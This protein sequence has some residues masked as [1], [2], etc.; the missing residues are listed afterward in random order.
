MRYVLVV[1]VI[2]L[3]AT[4]LLVP[5]SSQ[6]V[7]AAQSAGLTLQALSDE[8]LDQIEASSGHRVGVL[9]QQV[10]P[11][12]AAAQ[13][14]IKAGDVLLT[15]G[16]TGVASPQAVDVA[17]AQA[18]GAVQIMAMRQGA[19]GDFQP[20]TVTMGQGSGTG[21]PAQAAMVPTGGASPVDALGLV[22][23]PLPTE[24]LDAI[25]KASGHRVGIMVR[26]VRAGSPAAQGGIQSGDILLGI[27]NT[28]LASV[29][30]A[31]AALQGQAGTVPILG[32][33]RGEDGK[34]TMLAFDVVVPAPQAGPA[35][36]GATAPPATGQATQQPQVDTA[37]IQ[38]KLQALDAARQAGILTEAEYQSK[39]AALQAQMAPQPAAVSPETQ[40]KLQALDAARQAGVITQEEYQRKKDEL[41]AGAAGAAGAAGTA[42]GNVY[43]DPRN[44]FYFKP[45]PNWS[46]EQ[47]QEGQGLVLKR[48]GATMTLMIIQG[49][50]TA[51]ELLNMVGA[52][53]RTQTKNYQELDRGTVKARAQTASFVEFRGVNPA[54]ATARTR[55]TTLVAPGSGFA[56]VLSAPEAEFAVAKAD[57]QKLIKS[58][59]TGPWQPQAAAEPQQAATPPQPQAAP[60]QARTYSHTVGLTFRYGGDW[61]LQDRGQFL[62]LVPAD[63]AY[64]QGQ[65]EEV[66]VVLAEAG[67]AVQNGRP[68]NPQIAQMLDGAIN[69][70]GASIP[71]LKAE[72]TRT[73]GPETVGVGGPATAVMDWEGRTEQGQDILGRAYVSVVNQR[74]LAFMA[75]AY[76]QHLQK[77]DA[78]LQQMARSVAAGPATAPAQGQGGGEGGGM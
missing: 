11:G 48:G 75:L 72:I 59:G 35:A 43:Q 46:I 10:A 77:R 73:S 23:E 58:F 21:G 49:T 45:P 19:N 36:I 54:G 32:Q 22:L 7:S 1:S 4:G 42:G 57:L 55:L 61:T 78:D 37:Q 31:N 25:E 3:F 38:Q 16:S 65:P 27:G 60:G 71:T 66:Y 8:D 69:S 29:Q 76:E 50:G 28:R 52:Q 15:V 26:Q 51:S 13:A 53:M 9:V 12:S 14:G 40:Q 30:D 20:V 68:D 34:W 33:R 17:L 24:V 39:K 63:T 6:G 74:G 56:L 47:M 67:P 41:L 62:Q 44:R 2:A 5:A 64:S 70:L 18:Q